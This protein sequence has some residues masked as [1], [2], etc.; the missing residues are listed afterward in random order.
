MKS[1]ATLNVHKS[2]QFPEALRSFD[3]SKVKK[4]WLNSRDIWWKSPFLNKFHRYWELGIG[5]ILWE[6]PGQLPGGGHGNPLQYSC[7]ENPT[8]KPG[9][10]QSV[11]SQSFRHNWSD[12]ACTH[13]HTGQL[14]TE[15]NS[16]QIPGTN[17]KNKKVIHMNLFI[18]ILFLTV[19]EIPALR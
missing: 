17:L 3:C 15:D 19:F 10:L 12:W 18:V 8:E 14:T 9:G 13:I 7:L 11:G 1:L 16:L 6:D 5:H 2:F 4:I